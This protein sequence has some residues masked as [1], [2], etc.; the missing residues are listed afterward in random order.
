MIQHWIAGKPYIDASETEHAI[1]NPATGAQINT[2]SFAKKETCEKAIVAAQNAYQQWSL[3]TPALRARV[4]FA[5]RQLLLTHQDE[6][7]HVVTQEQGKT[8]D[9]A[10]GSLLRAI[11]LVEWY[12]G[13]STQWQTSL[14]NQAASDI[15]CY[16]IRQPLGVCLGVSPF[17]F[18]IM[19][20]MWMMIPAI[21]CGNSFILKPSEQDPSASLKLV[22]LLQEAGLPDGV[23][24]VVQGGKETVQHLV[25]HPT[26]VAVSAVA[27]TPVA[28]AIY[29]QAIALNK[30]A[31]TFGGAKNHAVVMSDA[32]MPAAAKAIVGAAYGSAGQRCMALSVV[33]TVGDDTAQHLLA[34]LLPMIQAIQVGAGEDP[35]TEMGPLISQT[36]RKKV[37]AWIEEGV[38]QGA[39]LLMDGRGF[40]HAGYPEGYF[41]GPCLFDKVTPAMSIYQQ[42]IF[43]P[44][45]VIVRAHS[46]E[47]AITL[48]NENRYGNGTAIFTCDGG[49]ARRFVQQVTVGMVG[50]N[51]PIPVP[52]VSHSFGGWKQSS[53]GDTMMHG[54]ESMHFYTRLKTV[55]SRW[56]MSASPA[57]VMPTHD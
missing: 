55:T 1:M 26:V 31:Q 37:L 46:L 40:V 11:E 9:D 21:A 25:E 47:E 3:S 12:C 32:D 54:T 14:T 15:D 19:V 49:A 28:Q 29:Q 20:P 23:V 16:T 57:F 36:Q 41:V 50:V 13:I 51:I 17:N 45:L 34:Q 43:G 10:K 39:E 48:I 4:L 7:I 22:A 56:S 38:S 6:L 35:G 18:P 53:F 8:L 42:E 24:N 52:I 30:R 33:V 27:S 5:F 2:V 44:V